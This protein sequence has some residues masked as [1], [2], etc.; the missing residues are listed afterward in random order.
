MMSVRHF[1]LT[2]SVMALV[3]SGAA[4]LSANEAA[5]A[6]AERFSD[7]ASK[8]TTKPLA[9]KPKIDVELR[10]Q[11]DE[12]DMLERAR[13]EAA[14]VK[15]ET[16]PAAASEQEI[17]RKAE[18]KRLAEKLRVAR[19]AREAKKLAE[20]RAAEQKALAEAPVIVPAPLPSREIVS[21]EAPRVMERKEFWNPDLAVGP[22]PE[23]GEFDASSRSS[24]GARP[25]DISGGGHKVAVLLVMTP[26][27]KGIRRLNKVADPILC[28][29]LGCYVSTGTATPARLMPQ[30][31]ATGFGNTLGMRAGAC[32]QSLECVFRDVDLGNGTAMLQPVDM[33]MMIHDRRQPQTV[34]ADR[35]CRITAGRLAC[36]RPIV[37]G[38]YVLWVVPEH[39]ANAAGGDVLAR[40]VAEGLP[41]LDQRADD[42]LSRALR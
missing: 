10:R 37:A 3:S 15:T 28:S 25:S 32:R 8:S 26:G 34:T 31:K 29:E 39:V 4:P 17:E 9:Q 38:D 41:S 20:K 35:S 11:A 23:R 6:L 36:G 42:A 21:R 27:S 22:L 30:R 13:R 2:A 24:L 19:E 40:A 1:I 5:K 7:G 18:L 33:K 14:D 16:V 12:R